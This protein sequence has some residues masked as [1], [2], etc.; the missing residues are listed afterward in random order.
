MQEEGG[1]FAIVLECVPASIAAFITQ[2]LKVV[3]RPSHGAHLR[4]QLFP[5]HFPLVAYRTPAKNKTA[6]PYQQSKAAG[7]IA[8]VRSGKAL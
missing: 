5:L 3:A 4:I 7:A 6:S 2:A 1:F 8:S